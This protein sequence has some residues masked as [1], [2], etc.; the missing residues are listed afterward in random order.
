MVGH[1]SG[2]SLSLSLAR[3][4][5]TSPLRSH[6]QHPRPRPEADDGAR[7][8]TIRLTTGD[9]D[10][11]RMRIASDRGGNGVGWRSSPID[12]IEARWLDVDEGASS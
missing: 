12:V 4:P 1:T 5:S 2:G 7:P 6:W 10:S 11:E 3:A 9:R 8:R